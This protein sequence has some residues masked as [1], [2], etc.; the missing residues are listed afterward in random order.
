[1]DV[2]DGHTS[3]PPG[4]PQSTDRAAADP[5]GG[6]AVSGSEGSSPAGEAPIHPRLQALILAGRYH[7]IE[8]DPGE[9]RIG[10][11]ENGPSATSLS[12]WAQAA[13]MWS[14][15]VRL[16]WRHLL[17]FSNTAPVVLLFNDGTAGLLTGV[18]T[19]HK[20]VLIKDPSGPTSDP[21]VPVDELRLAEV[22]SGDVVLLRASRGHAEVDAP[23]SLHWLVQLVMQEHRSLRDVGIASLT[24]SFLTIFPPLLVMT[25]VDKVLTHNSFSTLIL[26]STILGLGILYETLLGHARRLIVLVLGTR[27]DAKL[28]L[29]VFNRLLRLP[30]DY[31]ERHPAGE[32]MHKIHQVQKVREFLTG[33]LLTA[34]LDLMTLCVLLPFLFWLNA[35]LAWIV[36]SCACLIALIIMVYMKPL[37]LVYQR[38]VAAE[39]N[40]AAALGETIFGVRTVKSLALEPQRKALWDERIA[41]AGKWRL[42]YGKLANWPQTIVTPIERFMSMGVIL[43][44]AYWAMSDSTGYAVGSLFAFMMLSM[45]VAHPLVQLARLTDEFQDVAS[46]IGEAASVLNRPLEVDAPSGG[47]RQVH[48]YPPPARHQ[49]GLLRL[50]QDRRVRPARDQPAPSSSELRRRA[51]GQLPVPW[52]DPRQHPGGTTRSH[53]RGCSSRRAPCRCGGIHRADAEWL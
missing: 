34:F 3:G 41:E 53:T 39:T 9:F 15:A 30:I 18:N 12:S 24:L 33:K 16:R 37:G 49:S 25:V 35:S 5:G 52:L 22:W 32:T 40:K 7:G 42:V 38:V 46:A 13:G 20:V 23:F 28:N 2:N 1:V 19:E 17:R 45:R 51:A 36:L 43:L 31:F 27:I 6:M 11:G 21:A 50:P 14:R 44:G 8:L 48:H 29:H 47:M 4:R 10:Q 26:L